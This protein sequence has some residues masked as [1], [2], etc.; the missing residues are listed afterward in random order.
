MF[1][2]LVILLIFIF[3]LLLIGIFTNITSFDYKIYKISQNLQSNK[4]Q[5][6]KFSNDNFSK[7]FNNI[8][9]IDK[10]IEVE[11]VMGEKRKK[12]YLDKETTELE[13]FAIMGGKVE[14]ILTISN[15]LKI[16]KPGQKIYLR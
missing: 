12:V 13:V 15:L 8:D 4:K 1:R 16:I 5:S 10:A 11:V 6:E 3:S 2:E 14:N 7:S 9:N